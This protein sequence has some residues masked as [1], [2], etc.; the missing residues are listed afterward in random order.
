MHGAV[1]H[2]AGDVNGPDGHS[3]FPGNINQL[4]MKLQPYAKQLEATGGVI[5]EFVNPK[6]KDST[7][8]AFKKPTR[9]ECMMQDYPKSLPRTEAVGFTT[10]QEV[11]LVVALRRVVHRDVELRRCSYNVLVDFQHTRIHGGA[12]HMHHTMSCLAVFC[13]ACA[14]HDVMH[15]PS[16][17]RA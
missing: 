16:M 15:M 10:F 3:P 6:Y 8:T 11:R 13:V 9:L 14:R 2:C 1:I 4:V 7:R 12:R 5:A 17:N